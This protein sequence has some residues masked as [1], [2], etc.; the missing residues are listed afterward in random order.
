MPELPEVETVRRTLADRL[1]GRR[2][3]GIE[4]L[5][6]NVVAAGETKAIE[7]AVCGRAI[8]GLARRGKYLLFS[9]DSGD[10]LVIHLRMTGRL[11]CVR[12]R[13]P[14][15]VHTRL[16]LRLSGGDE[17]RLVDQRRFARAYV[18]PEGDVRGI[19]GLATA[20]V[21]PLADGFGPEILARLLQG[22]SAPI[23][24]FLL[25]QRHVAGLG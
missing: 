25:D 6:P 3:E 15:P 17:L 21:E 19:A 23:K 13:T 2:I 9:L 11:S 14:R 10:V 7:A 8:T 20:G 22:R 24:S 16:V 12:R 5:S 4:I 1:C 18:A